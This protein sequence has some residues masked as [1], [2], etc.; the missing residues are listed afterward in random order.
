MATDTQTQIV[1][2]DPRMEAL[3][4][5]ILT[6]TKDMIAGRMGDEAALPPAYKVAELTGLENQAAALGQTGI[7]AKLL[8][9]KT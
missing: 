7:G 4:L 1:R 6:D 9:V 2:E 3:R 5:G 8:R